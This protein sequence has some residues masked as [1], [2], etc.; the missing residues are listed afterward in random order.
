MQLKKQAISQMAATLVSVVLGNAILTFAVA[1]FILPGGLISGGVAGIGLIVRHFFEVNVDVGVAAANVV[2]FIAGAIVLGWKFALTTL[3]STFLYPAFLAFFI[4]LPILENLTSDPLLAA[5]YAGLLMGVGIGMVIRVGSSTGGM[6]IPP[7]II[8]KK[9]G[10][11]VPVLMYAFDTVILLFQVFFSSTEQVLYGILVVILTSIV[12]DRVMIIGQT[13]TQVMIVSPKYEEIN[14]L[15][16][17]DLDRG[18][19]LLNSVTGHLGERCETILTVVTH[20]QLPQLKELVLGVDEQAFIIVTPAN[21]VKG[22]GFT[23][24]KHHK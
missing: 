3:L 13:Q 19:T 16:Q 11:S 5:I 2:L 1:A 10:L 7:L 17:K 14:G 23:L 12:M 18:S 22:R 6:D 15:I 9:F 4:R 8:N 21:E 20:R 24:S